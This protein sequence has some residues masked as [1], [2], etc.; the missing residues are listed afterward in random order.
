MLRLIVALA[1]LLLPPLRALGDECPNATTAKAGFVLERQGSRSEVRPASD[2]FTHV[3]NTYPDGKKQDVIYYRGL[4]VISRYSDS[5]QSLAIPLSDLRTIF[6]L[7]VGARRAL[8]YVPAQPDKVGRPVSLEISVAGRE[9]MQIGPCSYDVLAV[10]SRSM[11]ADGRTTSQHT[12]LYS[13]D[14]GYTIGRRFDEGSGR[15]SSVKYE[16]IRPLARTAPL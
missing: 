15:E 2:L 5:V 7:D 6:P 12:D 8:T 10:R 13:P 3:V 16:T 4:L 9:K 14:L 1:C 11:G